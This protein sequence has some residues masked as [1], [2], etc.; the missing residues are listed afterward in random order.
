MPLRLMHWWRWL[1]RNFALAGRRRQRQVVAPGR[2]R[3]C[4]NVEEFEPRLVL[5]PSTI[6]VTSLSDG[7]GTLSQMGSNYFDTTLRGAI[8]NIASGGTIV[9]QSG[10]S[11]AIDIQS[12]GTLVLGKSMT[13][14]ETYGESISVEG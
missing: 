9:F 10:L 14:K 11:G 3:T 12:N 1:R 13:I 6:T 7:A 8:A 5:A 4:L 2:K